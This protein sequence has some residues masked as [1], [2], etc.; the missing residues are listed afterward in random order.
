MGY[1][2]LSTRLAIDKAVYWAEYG[3]RSVEIYSTLSSPKDNKVK[4][5]IL[6]L[7]IYP[8]ETHTHTHPSDICKRGSPRHCS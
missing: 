1:H 3:E 6:L 7:G 5:A 4:T 8:I 2:F